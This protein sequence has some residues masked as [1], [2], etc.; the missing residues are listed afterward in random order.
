MTK[1]STTNKLVV[2]MLKCNIGRAVWTNDQLGFPKTHQHLQQVAGKSAV[3]LYTLT[4]Q[5]HRE[6]SA[7]NP[8]SRVARGYFNWE[9]ADLL[10]NWFGLP[11][12]Q[13]PL[14]NHLEGCW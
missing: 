9:L 12:H 11:S 1:P 13:M 5:K 2:V 10:A 8:A 3:Y 7:V 6:N 4:V 14:T